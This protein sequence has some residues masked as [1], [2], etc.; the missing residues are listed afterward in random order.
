[1]AQIKLDVAWGGNANISSAFE[2]S[3]NGLEHIYKLLI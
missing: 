2:G 3:T 1:M